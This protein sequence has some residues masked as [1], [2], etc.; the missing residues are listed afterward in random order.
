[1]MKTKLVASLLLVASTD[2]MAQALPA[3]SIEL[4]CARRANAAGPALSNL[5]TACVEAERASL[6]DLRENWV[7]YSPRSRAQCL[8]LFGA[9]SLYSNLEACIESAEASRSGLGR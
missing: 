9:A 8:K 5:F 4:F 1:M 7:D 3:F 2:A 6:A